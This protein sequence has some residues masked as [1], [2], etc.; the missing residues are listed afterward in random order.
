M[1]TV[2]RISA[3]AALVTTAGLAQAAGGCAGGPCGPPGLEWLIPQ[4][5]AGADFRPACAGHDRCY[6]TPGASRAGCDRQFRRDLLGACRNSRRPVLCRMRANLY[7][8]ATRLFGGP[9]YAA[10]QRD[11]WPYGSRPV[12]NPRFV[13]RR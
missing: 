5:H 11:I 3:F 6:S 7:F 1:R 4:G 12:T 10:S 9:A 2:V 8:A 13:F